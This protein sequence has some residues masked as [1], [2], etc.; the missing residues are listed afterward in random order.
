MRD[1]IYEA[2]CVECNQPICRMEL[3]AVFKI[4][5]QLCESCYNRLKKLAK[6]NS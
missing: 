4:A 6:A 2:R 1:P 3:H 5:V